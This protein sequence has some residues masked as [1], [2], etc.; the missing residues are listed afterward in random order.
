MTNLIFGLIWTAITFICTLPVL[1]EG[2]IGVMLFLS[3]FWIIGIYLIKSGL[4]EIR[5][6]KATDDF[7][8]ECFGIIT[9]I[10]ETGTYVNS[11][12]ELK[13]ELKAYIPSL[14]RTISA[15]EKIGLADKVTEYDIGTY[16]LL[17]YYNGDV[18]IVYSVDEMILP[19]DAKLELSQAA[20]QQ[21]SIQDTIIIDG[22]EYVRK[23]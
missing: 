6:N 18:N 9:D 20:P 23:K 4:K 13:A 5:T 16:V 21:T 17:K 14:G 1:F 10:Y 22:V 19:A 3:I 2:E 15:A 11:V 12:P 7:G 8:E